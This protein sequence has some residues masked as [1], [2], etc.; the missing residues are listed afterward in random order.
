MS[1]GVSIVGLL[2]FSLRGAHQRID[3]DQLPVDGGD[4]THLFKPCRTH[5]PL[6]LTQERFIVLDLFFQSRA[7]HW[8]LSV[9]RPHSEGGDR[10]S[11]Q[12]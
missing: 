10:G 6:K 2:Q 1:Q 9:N 5:H 7:F 8:S 12:R 3:H 11:G 4:P